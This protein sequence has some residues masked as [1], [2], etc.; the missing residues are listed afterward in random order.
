VEKQKLHT[1]KVI[2]TGRCSRYMWN[3][4]VNCI[5]RV[6]PINW[7]VY[8]LCFL[9]E[10]RPC[11]TFLVNSRINHF[12][13]FAWR[14]K[15]AIKFAVIVWCPWTRRFWAPVPICIRSGQSRLTWRRLADSSLFFSYYRLGVVQYWSGFAFFWQNRAVNRRFFSI[16]PGATSHVLRWIWH[17]AFWKS[18][19]SHLLLDESKDKWR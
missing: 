11:N 7:K 14:F 1:C 16:G 3:F 17:G 9:I 2:L 15:W 12:D 13:N 19:I 5:S 8:L 4:F 18:T 6:L 10:K